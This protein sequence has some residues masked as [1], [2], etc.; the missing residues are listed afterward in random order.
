VSGNQIT[1]DFIMAKSTANCGPTV[2]GSSELVNLIVNGQSITVTGE[3][4][5]TFALSNG[6]LIINQQQQTT[7]ATSGE[8][9]VRA[10]RV[11]TND[12]VTGQPVADVALGTAIA[13][14]DCEGGSSPGENWVSGGGWIQSATD[15]GAKA[16]F[17]FVAGPGGQPNRGHLTVKDR[18]TQPFT[19]HGTVITSFTECVNGTSIFQAADDQGGV[20]DVRT[21]DE[22]EPGTSDRISF[23]GTYSNPGP[24]LLGG[25]IQN[26]GYSCM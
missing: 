11:L 20:V 1:T 3:P 24:V 9:A 16:T 26:H 17:G 6:S 12:T 25:N 18:G 10:L 19:F 2:G 7:G 23:E 5:Q 14:I 15:P 13:R 22:G 21:D 4:N 8:L